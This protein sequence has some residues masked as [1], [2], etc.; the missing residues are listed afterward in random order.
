MAKP[1]S[2]F[3][4]FCEYALFVTLALSVR[5]LPRSAAFKAG[6]CLG[7]IS[8][9]L[10]PRRVATARKNLARAFPEMPSSEL[11]ANIRKIFRHLGVSGVEML[12]L[13]LFRTNEDLNRYFRFEGLEHLETAYA[14]KKGVFLL[15]GH[16]GFWEVG[17]FF[18]P[19]LGYPVDFVAKKMKNPY[20]DRYFLKM[21]E[22]AGGHCLDS[23]R[24]AR[25]IV[26]SLAEKRGVAVLLDQ[27]IQRKEA[28]VVDFFGQPACTTPIITQIAMKQ[29]VPVVP[30]FVYRNNDN[31]Y[32]VI[33]EP[34]ILFEKNQS[35]DAII[36]NTQLLSDCIENAVLRDITQWFWVHRRWRN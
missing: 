16:I 4:N 23:K 31:T 11:D 19:M 20:V 13:D 10:L 26:K 1:R 30:V 17:T 34:P 22:A 12:R 32:N 27:H 36:R 14:M 15:T 8:R 7:G 21:R 5:L 25:R 35:E 2:T 29:G 33:I 18:M 3:Q 6:A 9:L 28:V 24:G